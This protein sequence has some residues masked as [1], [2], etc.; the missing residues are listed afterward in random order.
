[1]DP[2]SS[3]HSY[4]PLL[5]RVD[6]KGEPI[7]PRVNWNRNALRRPA[8]VGKGPE[9]EMQLCER[10]A[11]TLKQLIGIRNEVIQEEPVSREAIDEYLKHKIEFGL[12]R[13][14]E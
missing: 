7:F 1:M 8:C 13:G 5:N 12:L 3:R 11:L 4:Q 14:Q 9:S 10:D 6:G 2:R